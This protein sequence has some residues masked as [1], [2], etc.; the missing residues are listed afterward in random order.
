M[1]DYCNLPFLSEHDYPMLLT[2]IFLFS[3]VV[4]NT[5]KRILFMMANVLE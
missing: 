3:K 4:C 5:K 1:F 2:Q